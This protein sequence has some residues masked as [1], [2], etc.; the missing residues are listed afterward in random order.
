[1]TAKEQLYEKLSAEYDIFIDGLKGAAPDKIIESAYEKV[2]K[3]DILSCF[4]YGDS[5]NEQQLAALL[6]LDNPLD[7]LY[8]NW[9]HTDAS[10]MDDLSDSIHGFVVR[11]THLQ[12]GID[13]EEIADAGDAEP[14]TAEVVNGDLNIGDWVIVAPSDEYGYLLGIVTAIDKLG[15]PEHET[16]NHGDDVH[17]DFYA[18][19]Y[20][21]ERIAE[22][23]EDFSDLYGEP[24]TFDELPLDDVIMAPDSL[25]R[26]TEL[27]HDEITR[28]GGLLENCK[29]F[30]N[31]FPGVVEPQGD[32]E[33]ALM[34]RIEKNLA[35]Y[36]NSLM[37]FGNQE[38]ID[39]AGKIAAMRDVYDYMTTTRGFDDDEL[40]FYLQFQNPLEVVVD[41]WL[42]RNADNEDLSFT[43][44]FVFDKKDSLFDY[45]LI[46]D[47]EKPVE[48]R[49]PQKPERPP[50][51]KKRS[52][53]D[54]L[55]EG[56]EK[57][58]AYKEQ[59]AKNPENTTKHK[60]EGIL[61]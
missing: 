19:D 9:L 44:D 11:E 6:A 50:A 47:V 35:D 60:K 32:L 29:A 27:G 25:I 61:E 46:D 26:I 2:F 57:V 22:I 58:K 4:E 7:A 31:C 40:R 17:V 53:G 34:E 48:V 3:E 1:M 12:N 16:E 15:T 18:F 10:H 59:K 21:A 45:P 43:M 54:R 13:G 20:P 24:K 30:C 23:E 51:D 8:R 49:E 28:L 36:H 33:F 39:M 38:L 55:A 42:Q 56:N 52:I 37:G 14:P 5:F 41:A